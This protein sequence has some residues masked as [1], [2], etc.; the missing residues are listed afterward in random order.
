VEG[1]GGG[2]GEGEEEEEEEEEEK[3]EEEKEKEG[4]EKEEE[5]EKEEKEEEEGKGEKEEKEEKGRRRRRRRG[6]GRSRRRRGRR[7][8]R[9]RRNIVQCPS[10]IS[11]ILSFQSRVV[12]HNAG[13]PCFGDKQ[14]KTSPL[15]ELP[16]GSGTLAIGAVD[17]A[18]WELSTRKTETDCFLVELLPLSSDV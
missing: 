4:E 3:E 13:H 8:R 9:R 18:I 11:F 12:V 1:G 7:R 5:E 14:A 6:R 15:K 17:A 10:Y 16:V 2:G